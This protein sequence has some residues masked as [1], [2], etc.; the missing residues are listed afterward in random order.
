MQLDFLKHIC[1]LSNNNLRKMLA[2]TLTDYQYTP[3]ENKDFVI[4]EGTLPICLI[5]HLDTVFKR[6]PQDFFY[7]S[8]QRVLWSPQGAGF[9]DRAGVYIIL[10][11]L[12]M[13]YR[14]SIIFTLGEEIG[15]I[16]AKKICEM[17]PKCCPFL[18]CKALIE[19]D[20]AGQKDSV[21]YNCDNQSFEHYIN[22]FGFETDFGTFTDISFLAPE[23]QIA[24]VNLSVGYEDEH[25]YIER[26]YCK[27][28]DQ[29]IAKVAQILNNAETMPHF[30]YVPL[31]FTH[32]QYNKLCCVCGKE[33]N[34]GYV[35]DLAGDQITFCKE[36]YNTCKK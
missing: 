36:C 16:G 7:D 34:E 25:S 13:G 19:L 2:K 21:Y 14:P 33:V 29:T 1:K 20:R 17:F 30:A 26:L 5:A 3:I 22:N 8:E 6:L 31:A 12:K 9:D 18:E 27:W 11:L 4:A 10:M 35:Y 28:T 24:A 23:W 15:G 32:Q